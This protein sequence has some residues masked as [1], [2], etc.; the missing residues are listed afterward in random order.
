MPLDLSSL[1]MT[2][3][4]PFFLTQTFVSV[5]NVL[6]GRF[7]NLSLTCIFFVDFFLKH[8]V[9]AMTMREL[10]EFIIDPSITSDNI[11]QYLEK[12]REILF[13]L[14]LDFYNI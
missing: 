14:F 8:E 2:P 10:F 5:V 7:I 13:F 12:V 11:N 3:S 9:P 1:I 4:L 6:N